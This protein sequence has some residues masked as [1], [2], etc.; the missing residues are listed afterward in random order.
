MLWIAE[1]DLVS[2]TNAKGKFNTTPVNP[3]PVQ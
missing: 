3:R 2:L 1:G